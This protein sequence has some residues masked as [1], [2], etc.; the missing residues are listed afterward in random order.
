MHLHQ[1]VS[2]QAAQ[3][4]ENF[5]CSKG[6]FVWSPNTDKLGRFNDSTPHTFGRRQSFYIKPTPGSEHS[7]DS[8]NTLP[9]DQPV[10][11]PP[12][13]PD[14][15]LPEYIESSFQEFDMDE[16]LEADLALSEHDERE[17]TLDSVF[18]SSS[19]SENRSNSRES[20]FANTSATS[21]EADGGISA[22]PEKT[23]GTYVI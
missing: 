8:S 17:L 10:S 16:L 11:V 14:L 22:I 9:T 15:A 18:A 7:S 6:L 20:S 23:H 4:R 13:F 5:D 2:T 19:S 1:R 3:D 21:E 12:E